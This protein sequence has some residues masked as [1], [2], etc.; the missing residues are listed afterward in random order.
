MTSFRR[1]KITSFSENTFLLDWILQT[2]IE[3]NLQ[4][5]WENVL[6]SDETKIEL[7]RRNAVVKV[8]RNND[9]EYSTMNIIPKVK[10]GGRIKHD[11][12][13]L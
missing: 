10:F 9:T 11:L 13:L 7:F 6:W 4:H 2:S 12:G 1:K 5:F 8:W 3:S